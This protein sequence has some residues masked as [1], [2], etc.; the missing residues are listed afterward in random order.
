MFSL[1]ARALN[2]V[3]ARSLPELVAS[4]KSSYSGVHVE[5]VETVVDFWRFIE[6]RSIEHQLSQKY[7]FEIQKNEVGL[8]VFRYKNAELWFPIG[9]TPNDL[10]FARPLLGSIECQKE[11]KFSFVVPGV[12]PVSSL[13]SAI[14]AQQDRISLLRS[15][16]HFPEERVGDAYRWWTSFLNEQE[17]RA[18]DM[19]VE[20]HDIRLELSG[21]VISRKV[22]SEEQKAANKAKAQRK[23]ELLLRLSSHAC[24]DRDAGV[25]TEPGDHSS[26]LTAIVNHVTVSPPASLPSDP[27]ELESDE[28]EDELA[29]DKDEDELSS[30][31][32][33]SEGEMSES[34]G[35]LAD[36]CAKGL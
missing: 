25:L 36:V 27:D 19:C 30:G 21:I 11:L 12:L 8:V 28:D 9:R 23:N 20:C 29:S 31:M 4:I 13:R 17:Q 32:S 24:P 3:S 5:H 1:I 33:S 26:I 6:P 10:Q 35:M 14:N 2:K 22:R 16:L 15:P 7:S 34:D 18:N